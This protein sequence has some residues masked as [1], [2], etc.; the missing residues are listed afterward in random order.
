MQ[1]IR[2]SISLEQRAIEAK[3]NEKN[4]FYKSRLLLCLNVCIYV[5]AL[6]QPA[7]MRN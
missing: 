3:A 2:G 4:A 5:T 6:F 1:L 7:L